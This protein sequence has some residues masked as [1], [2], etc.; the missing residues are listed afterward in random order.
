MTAFADLAKRPDVG[1]LYYFNVSRDGGATYDGEDV[2]STH[3][4]ELQ[5]RARVV[6]LGNLSRNLG[7]DYGLAAATVDVTLDNSD[8]ELDWLVNPETYATNV[9]D[10]VWELNCLLY[11]PTNRADFDVKKLGNFTLLSPPRRSATTIQLSLADGGVGRIAELATAP[12][13][14]NWG[15]LG[16]PSGDSN[17]PIGL[18]VLAGASA[19]PSWGTVN[20]YDYSAPLPLIWGADYFSLTRA[21]GV[22]YPICAVPAATSGLTT[23]SIELFLDGVRVPQ[24]VGGITVWTVRR[25]PTISVNGKNWHI[26]WLS[27]DIQGETHSSATIPQS[28]QN[29]LRIFKDWFSVQQAANSRIY[30]WGKSTASFADYDL[31]KSVQIRYAL[32]S[33]VSG[34]YASISAPAVAKEIAANCLDSATTITNIDAVIAARAGYFAS[35]S[36]G[37]SVTSPAFAEGAPSGNSPTDSLSAFRGLCTAGQ[38]DLF[39]NWNGGLQATAPL[40]DYAAQTAT[41]AKLYDDD[42]GEIAEYV[43]S[44]GQRGAP[45]NTL[46]VAWKNGR[47]YGP[48]E[49]SAVWLKGIEKQIDGYWLVGNQRPDPNAIRNSQ[50]PIDLTYLANSFDVTIRTHVT[51]VTGLNGLNYELGDFVE[52]TWKR[53]TIGGPYIDEIFRIEGISFSPLDGKTQLELVWYGDLRNGE[54]YPYILDNETSNIRVSAS[55]GR[56]ITLTN[57]SAFIVF[58]SG[59]TAADGIQVGDIVKIIDSTESATTFYRNRTLRVLSIDDIVTLE[60]EASDWPGGPHTITNWVIYRG[61]ETTARAAYYGKT[62]TIIGETYNGD[63]I[64]QRLLEG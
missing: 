56:T 38:F 23:G 50:P 5:I 17:M 58:S 41:L 64:T 36:V 62:C 46:Q 25:T 27:L 9:I 63:P 8:G 14:L 37:S 60:V 42:C 11:L 20:G 61:Q 16:Y 26:L 1:C 59:D 13:M 12:S 52:F 57:G 39:F 53:G 6:S 28:G 18:E 2:F 3:S 51:V 32:G 7:P 33:R 4:L 19:G 31:I 40:D 29:K 10:S 24:T 22:C 34:S 35:G 45:F 47:T 44:Q 55:G 21:Y 30:P 15:A 54:V 48:V 49:T 43:P